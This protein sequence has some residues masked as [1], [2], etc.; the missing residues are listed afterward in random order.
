MEE[1][2]SAF[3]S[4]NHLVLLKIAKYLHPQ[5]IVRTFLK[6]NKATHSLGTHNALWRKILIYEAVAAAREPNLF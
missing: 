2:K 3:S 6:L 4:F 5:D 1:K